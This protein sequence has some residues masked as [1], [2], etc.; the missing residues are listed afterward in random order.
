MGHQL[1]R[2]MMRKLSKFLVRTGAVL[3]RPVGENIRDPAD[4]ERLWGL[5]IGSLH[6]VGL[7]AVVLGIHLLIHLK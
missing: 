3:T 7:L 4:S 2:Q 6:V 5:L 1:L